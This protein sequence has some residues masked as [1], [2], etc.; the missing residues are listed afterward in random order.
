MASYGGVKVYRIIH[1]RIPSI[2]HTNFGEYGDAVHNAIRRSDVVLLEYLLK[3][4]ADPGREP[5]I[6]TPRFAY[7]YIPIENTV[8]S[9]T[10]IIAQ[11][12][13]NYGARVQQTTALGIAASLGHIDMMDFLL[14]VG[15]DINAV[16]ED[17]D[18]LYGCTS[19]FGTPLHSAASSAQVDGAR[20]LVEHGARLDILNNSRLTA[21]EVASNHGSIEVMRVL[22]EYKDREPSRGVTAFSSDMAV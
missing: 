5:N 2:I 16:F 15:A 13:I 12:L 19:T 6:E 14:E 1:T 10:P 3:N 4:G 8:L 7:L 20:Y 17:V 18:G 21:M 11:L 9:S 22:H